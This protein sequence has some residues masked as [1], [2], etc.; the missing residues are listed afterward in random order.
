MREQDSNISIGKNYIYHIHVGGNIYVGQTSQE[1]LKRIEQHFRNAYYHERHDNGGRIGDIYDRMRQHRMQDVV[2]E[3]YPD[4]ADYGIPDIQ[5]K[6]QLFCQEWLPTDRNKTTSLLDFAEVFH[7]MYLH[8]QGKA[9]TNIEVGG[10]KV[11]SWTYAGMISNNSRP[12]LTSRTP[13]SEAYKIIKKGGLAFAQVQDLTFNLVEMMF[14]K[15]W[16]N[17]IPNSTFMQAIDLSKRKQ[18]PSRPQNCDQSW[19]DYVTQSLGPYILSKEIL[20]KAIK[21]GKGSLTVSQ[22]VLQEEAKNHM[23]TY[24][25][26]PRKKWLTTLLNNQ[27]EF[28][29]QSTIF[30]PKDLKLKPVADYL[31][32]VLRALI[33]EAYDKQNKKYE[34]KSA[35]SDSQQKTINRLAEIVPVR[36]SAFWGLKGKQKQRNAGMWLTGPLNNPTLL[37]KEWYQ[38]R[39]LLYFDWIYKQA[40]RKPISLQDYRMKFSADKKSEGTK[41]KIGQVLQADV[42]HPQDAYGSDTLS[43]AMRSKYAEFCPAYTRNWWE[44]YRPMIAAWRDKQE[45]PDFQSLGDYHYY[46]TQEYDAY[47]VYKAKAWVNT[48][49]YHNLKY[50]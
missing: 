20:E 47:I 34:I 10:R 19:Y 32:V 7:T 15:D 30:E 23:W 36:I 46:F 44:F 33:V 16:P 21:T 17:N 35:W 49:D 18:L 50:Y 26:K 14:D 22:N 45:K 39:S 48:M 25:F 28:K 11:Q 1:G 40:N 43:A 3:I 24:F 41:S 8:G 6:Y 37:P 27:S 5:T 29:I 4:T 2:V 13:L 12:I 9:L 38:Y 31:G 42:I